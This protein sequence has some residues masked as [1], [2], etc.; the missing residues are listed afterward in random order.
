MKNSRSNKGFTILELMIAT[1]AF[2]V[3]LAIVVT[4]FLQV[5]RMYVKG[6]N[7]SLVQED[8]RNITDS[9]SNDIRF[10]GQTPTLGHISNGYFCVG[11]H[12]YKFKPTNPDHLGY[13][14][15]VYGLIRENVGATCLQPGSAGDSPTNPVEMLNN[16]MQLNK[17]SLSCTS[18]TCLISIN[19]V[20]YGSDPSVL[21]PNATDP[22]ARCVGSLAGSQFCANTSYT[23]TVLQSF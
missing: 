2:T 17:L 10:S 11:N 20:F 9:I 23:T 7:L 14:G 13:P 19:V 21:T 15:A 12:R 8:T 4:A 22:N 5:G 1:T 18:T 3:L 16:G 6:V